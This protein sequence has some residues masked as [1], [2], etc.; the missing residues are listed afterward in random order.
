MK[1]RARRSFSDEYRAK[2]LEPKDRARLESLE[3]RIAYVADGG[4]KRMNGETETDDDADPDDDKRGECLNELVTGL[5]RATRV[6]AKYV[7]SSDRVRSGAFAPCGLALYRH[8][9]YF[10]GT[11]DDDPEQRIF[12]AERFVHAERVRGDRFEVPEDFDVRTFFGG[13]FG[14]WVSDVPEDVV[15]EFGP[16]TFEQLSLRR[17]HATQGVERTAR[18]T[19]VLR[20]RVGTSPDLVSWVLGWGAWVVVHAPESLRQKVEADHRAA[21][22]SRTWSGEH[23]WE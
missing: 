11:W 2:T 6:A 21:T 22:V 20:M 13:A 5:V 4:V 3:R 7:S 18:D 10:V 16:G 23:E 1:R 17:Y 15:L 9:L 8:G 19:T 12:A 14:V